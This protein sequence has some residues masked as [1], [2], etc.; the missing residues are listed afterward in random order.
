MKATIRIATR[1]YEFIEFE[2]DVETIGEAVELYEEGISLANAG[3]GLTEKEFNAVLDEYLS[4]GNVVNGT[5][6]YEKMNER[7]RDIVQSVK[8]SIKRCKYDARKN[9]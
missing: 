8:R 6:H 1:Q 2:K 4:T 7:Q 9:V 5:E 3:E